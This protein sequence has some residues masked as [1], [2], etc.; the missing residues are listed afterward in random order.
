[1]IIVW[2]GAGFVVP[3]IAVVYF[4]G[5][6]FGIEYF[7]GSDQYCQT[8]R[9]PSL[10]VGLLTAATLWPLGRALREEGSHSFF[11][12][13]VHWWAI[14][15]LLLGTWSLFLPR[16]ANPQ[17]LAGSH[18]DD[19]SLDDVPFDVGSVYIP[20]ARNEDDESLRSVLQTHAALAKR[21]KLESYVVFI[22]N[23]SEQCTAFEE[24][25]RT[26]ELKQALSGT[27]IVQLDADQWREELEDTGF[28]GDSLP[29]ISEFD[30]GGWLK[31]QTT[32]PTQWRGQT[33]QAIALSLAE[34]FHPAATPE[35]GPATGISIGKVLQDSRAEEQ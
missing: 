25:R 14:P 19:E 17:P 21:L 12:I 34:F 22:S 33:P 1:M 24:A 23:F 6:E 9:W 18:I 26:T 13:P 28:H 16:E 11:F 8:H 7:A 15:A 35:D 2:T 20:V 32:D 31:G 30:A 29:A 10:L 5:A 4:L 3:M 27:Y